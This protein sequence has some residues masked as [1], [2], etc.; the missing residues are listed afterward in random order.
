MKI[1]VIV[2]RN[3]I[4]KDNFIHD[5]IIIENRNIRKKIVVKHIRSQKKGAKI[6][7]PFFL[8]CT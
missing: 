2:N 5:I 4:L 1:E 7:A 6:V 8:F 3:S